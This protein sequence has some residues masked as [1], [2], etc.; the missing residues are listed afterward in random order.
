MINFLDSKILKKFLPIFIFLFAFSLRVYGINWD[1]NQHLHPD[2]RF[3]TMTVDSMTWPSTLSEYFNPSIS[4]LN[5]YNIKTMFFVYGTLPT[6]IV[7]YFS[8]FNIFSE[9]QY[10]NIALTGRLL[11]ALFDTGSV[12]LVLLVAQKIFNR[13]VGLLATFLYSIMVL[14]IQLSHF[15]AVDTFLNFFLILSFYFLSKT[16]F[17]RNLQN[18]ILLGI[19]YG[20]ALACKISALYFIPVVILGLFIHFLKNKNILLTTYYLLLFLFFAYLS[21]RIFDPHV[22]T[23]NF[24]LSKISPQFVR[25]IKEL[26]AMGVKDSMFPP[27][28]QWLKITPIL[29]PLK[30]IVLWGLGLPLGIL[31]VASV[32]GNLF[33][34]IK[35][36]LRLNNY[37]IL[38]NIHNHLTPERYNYFLIL[39]W[40]LLLF[41][42]QGG[43]VV[44]TMRYFLPIYPFLAILSANFFLYYLFPIIKKSFMLYSIFYILVL[45]WPLSFLSIYSHPHSRVLAS[46]WIY[47]NISIGSTLSCDS[48]DDCLPLNVEHVGFINQYKILTMEPFTLDT[49]EKQIKFTKQLKEL[50]YFILTSNRAWGSLTKV[51]DKF[52]FMSNFYKDLFA[53]K[54]NFIKVAEITSYPTVPILN[55]PIP[56]DSS[57]EAFTVYDHPK[58]MI[59]K[60]IN[61]F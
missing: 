32:L 16:L 60:K 31:S 33:V 61:S 40:V 30:N 54:L 25:N 22:F 56:D 47:Q 29:F 13:K 27:A 20:L 2:E 55:I 21:F 28:I 45:I 19:S 18:P 3:L 52:P 5:P 53:G 34:V 37:K 11:S 1:Q 59:Y 42:Y 26:R 46:E 41:I 17:K 35:S 4:K 7:K 57:E 58:V 8:R 48:W 36:L 15:F 51:P 43:Q 9:F 50:D 10:N 49:P 24:L 44:S 23:D 39:F 38:K 6:T 14:P 12:I